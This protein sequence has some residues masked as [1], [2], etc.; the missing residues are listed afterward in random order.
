M[1]IFVHGIDLTAE[2]EACSKLLSEN[3]TSHL[4]NA[5]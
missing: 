1:L 2:C 5:F 3:R 4:S